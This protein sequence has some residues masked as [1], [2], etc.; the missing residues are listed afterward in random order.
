[1]SDGSLW[2]STF[3]PN[4]IP[5]ARLQTAQASLPFSCVEVSGSLGDVCNQVYLIVDSMYLS[6]GYTKLHHHFKP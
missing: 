2:S 5:Y 6:Y 3:R 1:M 4:S